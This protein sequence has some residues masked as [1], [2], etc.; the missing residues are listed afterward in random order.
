MDIP[1]QEQ[2]FKIKLFFRGGLNS[3][4]IKFELPTISRSVENK[5]SDRRNKITEE[6]L[7][8]ARLENYDRPTNL[9]T[10]HQTDIRDHRDVHFQ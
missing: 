7:L 3:I 1:A 10:S 4:L 6:V 9:Q 8:P 5:C 2:N